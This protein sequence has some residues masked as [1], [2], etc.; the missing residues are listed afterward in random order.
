MSAR[1]PT[2]V[3]TCAR[4]VSD[5]MPC[6]DHVSIDNLW[7]VCNW[8]NFGSAPIMHIHQAVGQ[9]ISHFLYKTTM[10]YYGIFCERRSPC[11]IC[12][13]WTSARFKYDPIGGPVLPPPHPTKT[14]L[15]D[16][17]RPLW[18]QLSCWWNI[19]AEYA[20]AHVTYYTLAQL[21]W[22]H[23]S[24]AR[25]QQCNFVMFRWELVPSACM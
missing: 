4:D 7:L 10:Y 22:P 1:Y 15:Y 13:P 17:K 16:E 18:C 19:D 21:P 24:I 9:S 23:H 14:L 2:G 5:P 6:Y 20:R 25:I 3:C 12:E 11:S 8:V